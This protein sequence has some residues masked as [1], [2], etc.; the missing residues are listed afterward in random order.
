MSAHTAVGAP[1]A[2]LSRNGAPLLISPSS[3]T[4]EGQ[5]IVL[6]TSN[7]SISRR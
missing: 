5:S 6:G 1:F 7:V 2:Q 3:L 4:D